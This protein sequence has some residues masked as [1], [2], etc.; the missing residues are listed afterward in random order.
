MP[1]DIGLP[2]TLSKDDAYVQGMADGEKYLLHLLRE[3]HRFHT[4]HDDASCSCG[5]EFYFSYERSLFDDYLDHIE[6]VT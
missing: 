2:E 4:N 5:K 3:E 1:S 6:D